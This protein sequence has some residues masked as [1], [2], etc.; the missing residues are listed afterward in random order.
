MSRTPVQRDE[1][2]VKARRLKE[3]LVANGVPVRR[4]YLYGSVA[5]GTPHA[6]SDIDVAVV[7]EPF[8]ETRHEENM[9]A[10]KL[11]RDIDTRIEPI[12]LHPDD[13]GK[14]HF[15]LPQEVEREGVEV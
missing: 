6:W 1:G 2:I 12:C 9:V 13:F 3:A 11:R 10:R 7:C 4:L 8:R 14:P 5:R 15:T